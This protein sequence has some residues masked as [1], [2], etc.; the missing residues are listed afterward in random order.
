[1]LRFYYRIVTLY[2]FAQPFRRLDDKVNVNKMKNVAICSMVALAVIMS[3]TSIAEAAPVQVE[4]VQAAVQTAQARNVETVP[5][6]IE[7]LYP[8]Q[9]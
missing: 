2:L 8:Q 6:K 4:S 7:N 1:M 9:V 5:L 3:S